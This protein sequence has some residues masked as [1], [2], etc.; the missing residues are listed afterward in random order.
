MRSALPMGIDE[1]TLKEFWLQKL[2]PT[3]LAIISGLDG[4]LESLAERAD[5]VADASAGHDLAAVAREPDRLQSMENAITALTTQSA[6]HRSK[7]LQTLST[8]SVPAD[9]SSSTRAPKF[10]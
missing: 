8:I 2:P 4:S 9:V 5:R 1:S 10:P 3:I 6:S 7:L